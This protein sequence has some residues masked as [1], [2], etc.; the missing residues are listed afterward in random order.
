M[1]TSAGED[2][3]LAMAT[4]AV[5][6]AAPVVVTA[7]AVVMWRGGGTAAWRTALRARSV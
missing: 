6:V 4:A 2:I 7:P 5:A 3:A 1:S